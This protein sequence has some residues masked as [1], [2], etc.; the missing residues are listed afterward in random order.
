M[1]RNYSG[2]LSSINLSSYLLMNPSYSTIP[3]TISSG[4]LSISFGVPY[5]AFESF[6][7][8]IKVSS[9]VLSIF[10]YLYLLAEYPSQ[11]I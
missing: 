7:A 10:G 6:K 5:P 11:V 4:S 8:I 9:N 3:I 1:A 2:L